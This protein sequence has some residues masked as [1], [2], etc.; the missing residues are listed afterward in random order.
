[1]SSRTDR[2]VTS[3]GSALLSDPYRKLVALALA[4]A[5]WFYLDNQVSATHTLRL[6]L[7]NVNQ[8]SSQE[9][10]P[11]QLAVPIAHG[12]F[13][14]DNYSNADTGETVAEV[15]LRFKGPKS[16]IQELQRSHRFAVRARELEPTVGG[17]EFSVEDLTARQ[18]YLDMIESMSPARVRVNLSAVGDKTVT[19]NLA[20]ASFAYP[21]GMDPD[22][23][24]RMRTDRAVLSPPNVVLEGPK[25]VLDQS[26][27]YAF[28]VR[29]LRERGNSLE[30]Q[31]VL[32]S[33]GNT[34]LRL[35]QPVLVTIPLEPVRRPYELE[36]PVLVDDAKLPEEQ[37]GQWRPVHP[38]KL[39]TIQAY[40]DI[41][42]RYLRGSNSRNA[43]ASEH[44]RL[45][46]TLEYD[47]RDKDTATREAVLMALKLTD[48]NPQEYRLAETITIDLSRTQ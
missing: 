17:F 13:V 44:L 7:T 27:N 37:R 30:G 1:M 25:A 15:V 29:D 12:L 43:F 3:W 26:N 47:D 19:P 18:E 31:L 41:E 16:R 10:D 2:R 45:V 23:P 46:V 28:V 8:D 48:I 34:S 39:T 36:I 21:S 33:T 38:T 9:L 35:A 40:G 42:I 6:D 14:V 22:V 5:L 4:L 32:D 20:L 11:A 24:K